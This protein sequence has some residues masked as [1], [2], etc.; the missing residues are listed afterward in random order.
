MATCCSCC[1]YVLHAF[2]TVEQLRGP[3]CPSIHCVHF[4]RSPR[5]L[6]LTAIFCTRDSL[7][8]ASAWVAT[9][10]TTRWPNGT[11]GVIV[12]KTGH[13]LPQLLRGGMRAAFSDSRFHSRHFRS[14][15][16]S[17]FLDMH[18]YRRLL[19]GDVMQ[20]CTQWKTGVFVFK[21]GLHCN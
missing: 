6:I 17:L 9:Q 10:H 18:A 4:N 8:S 2:P 1:F 16:L 7:R 20:I 13:A 15:S 5:V 14:R 11:R 3:L 19:H 21:P 12:V